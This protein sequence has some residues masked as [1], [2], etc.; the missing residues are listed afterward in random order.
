MLHYSLLFHL[1]KILPFSIHILFNEFLHVHNIRYHTYAHHTLLLLPRYCYHYYYYM[2]VHLTGTRPRLLWN[3][4]IIYPFAEDRVRGDE[5][6]NNY[7]NW[8]GYKSAHSKILFLGPS[9]THRGFSIVLF[10]TTSPPHNIC[11]PVI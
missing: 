4:Y 5:N 10:L 2:A 11:I 9:L 1:S 8:V 7:N 3:F 6:E